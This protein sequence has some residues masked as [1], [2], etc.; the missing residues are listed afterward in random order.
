VKPIKLYPLYGL[1]EVDLD[2]PEDRMQAR[3]VLLK[4]NGS[5][6]MLPCET[7]MEMNRI[8]RK[9]LTQLLFWEIKAGWLSSGN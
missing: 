1:S 6:I 5:L 3:V 9:I 2:G 7:D 8:F 4:A